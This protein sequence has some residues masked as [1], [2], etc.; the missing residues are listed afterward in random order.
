[1]PDRRGISETGRSGVLTR[2][3]IAERASSLATP[4]S[5]ILLTRAPNC[6]AVI[7][8]C[9]PML[10]RATLNWRDWLAR[11]LAWDKMIP[12]GIPTAARAAVV[13]RATG[14]MALKVA[15]IPPNIWVIWGPCCNAIVRGLMP[16][17]RVVK[18][19]LSWG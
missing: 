16:V 2:L 12:S 14:G 9:L 13:A 8:P 15:P 10:A 3:V 7:S 4:I 1:M 11:S 19:S 17:V 18:I 5:R 6:P